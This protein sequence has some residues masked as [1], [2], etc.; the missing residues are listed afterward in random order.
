MKKTTT[1]SFKFSNKVKINFEGG[2]LT[3]DGGMLLFH[4]FCE[5]MN[6]Q[7]LLAKHLPENRTGFYD[8]K[9]PEIIYQQINRIIA[10][11]PSNNAAAY[12]KDDPVLNT[13]HKGKI[14]SASTAC[15]LEQSFSFGDLKNLQTVQEKI[16]DQAYEIEQP[17][18]VWLDVDT[19]YD[20]ASGKLD[21]SKYN[22]H[23]RVEGFNPVVVFNGK[24]GDFIKGHLRPGN[25]YCSKKIVEF[26][27][28]VIVRYKRKQ[29]PV[30][31]RM[32]SGFASPAVY[33]MCEKHN[34]K[35][36]IKLKSNAV[37]KR[38]FEEQVLTEEI[39]ENKTEVFSEFEYK[40]KSW[41]KPRRVLVRVQ[42]KGD[43]L[44]P[45]CTAIVSNDEECTSEDGFEFYN[46]RATVENSIQEGKE[47]FSWDHLSNQSFESNAVKFQ[48]FLTAVLLTQLL[49]RLCL[50]EKHKTQTIQTIRIQII[51]VATR[52]VKSS[53][54]LIFKCASCFPFQKLFLQV[55]KTVQS[56][57]QFG[58]G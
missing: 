22:T 1:K 19:T 2:Q 28:P 27:E 58:F 10:G 57:P 18:E 52:V 14:A 35:Y 24:N 13:I 6:V 25:F 30:K 44:F 51:K 8:H 53:R 32:D 45:I 41:T 31:S 39:Y 40:A 36:Y 46:G 34:A 16:L 42:W 33:E 49:R 47:G 43:Q 55:L 7:G 4:E 12:L 21:G 17:E 54:K 15:R 3:S 29:V 48:I 5:K 37:I 23:Y 9:K 38:T 11:Y 50:P 56:L 26:L 20:P